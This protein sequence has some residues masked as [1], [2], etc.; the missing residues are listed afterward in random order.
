[1]LAVLYMTLFMLQIIF[2]YLIW[3]TKKTVEKYIKVR[4]GI[5]FSQ[6]HNKRT[7]SKSDQ[8]FY[9]D[10]YDRTNTN[11]GP[12]YEEEFGDKK[13]GFNQNEN[14]SFGRERTKEE[15]LKDRL[16]Y[17]DISASEF[18]ASLEFFNIKKLPIKERELKKIYRENAKK[19]HPDS[20]GSSEDF[21][22]FQKYYDIIK[23]ANEIAQNI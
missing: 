1:M 9:R 8:R 23:N 19:Y 5:Y 22:A 17:R 21:T 10:F 16:K 13:N 6:E 4:N 3:V 14:N 12:S 15:K 11:T 2:L 18:N 20:G 7:N